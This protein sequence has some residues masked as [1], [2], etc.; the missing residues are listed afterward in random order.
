MRLLG[1]FM[2]NLLVEYAKDVVRDGDAPIN[3]P[4]GVLALIN[5]PMRSERKQGMDIILD[6]ICDEDVVKIS[7]SDKKTKLVRRI[8]IDKQKSTIK[9]A[10]FNGFGVIR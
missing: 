2:S 5:S 1:D 6:G 3:S 8:D 9:F 10:K 7:M 4:L